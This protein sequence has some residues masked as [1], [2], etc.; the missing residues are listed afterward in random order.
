[1]RILWVKV[2]GLWPLTTGG[3]LRSFHLVDQ[4]SRRHD[5]TV[6]TTHGPEDDPSGLMARLSHCAAVRSVPYEI[7][8]RESSRFALALVR[9][10][11]SPMPVDVWKCHVAALRDEVGRALRGGAVDVCVADF[12]AATPNVPFA[13]SRVPVVLFAHNVEHQ[14]WKRLREHAA[15]PWKRAVLELEWRKMRRYEARA[16]K[17][18]SLTLAVSDAD[19][20]LLATNAPGAQIAAIPTGVDTE[21]FQP[22]PDREQPDRLVFTGAMDWYPNED[23]LLHF[24]EHSLPRIR[25]AVPGVSLALIGRKPSA[26]LIEAARQPGVT[27]TGTVPD[28]RPH[29]HEGAVFIVPLRIGGGTRLKIFEALA[30]GKAVVSTTVGAEGLPMQPGTHFDQADSADGFANAVIRLLRDPGR[31]AALARAG[32]Q[33][34][35]E[36]YSWSQVSRTFEQR[37][38]EAVVTHA[39]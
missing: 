31:R 39:H 23:G 3:R 13:G 6:L 36:R 30:M 35:T 9:S 25:A 34:V 22:E 17:D 37:L 26:R 33:L 2:G 12:L 20:D 32:R 1:M 16:C 11:P 28:V 5:V 10:W 18:A 21:F 7:P 38:S 29:V 4:L 15:E 19:R 14:I 27:V 24:L 8:R